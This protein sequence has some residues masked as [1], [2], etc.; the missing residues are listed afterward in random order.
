MVKGSS[1]ESIHRVLS[2]SFV[3]LLYQSEFFRPTAQKA[4]RLAL[5]DPDHGYKRTT[6]DLLVVSGYLNQQLISILINH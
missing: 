6:R 3:A 2:S 5:T 1:P 4:Y